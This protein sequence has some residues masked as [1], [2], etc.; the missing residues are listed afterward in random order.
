MAENAFELE[1]GQKDVPYFTNECLRAQ[2]AFQVKAS[3][4]IKL[5]SQAK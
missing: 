4:A 5:S 3:E 2:L 1:V